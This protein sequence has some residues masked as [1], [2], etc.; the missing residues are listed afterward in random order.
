MKAILTHDGSIKIIL[1]TDEADN[2]I[3]GKFL[4]KEID[5]AGE[6]SPASSSARM[7]MINQTTTI[8]LKRT[9]FQH[10]ADDGDD[11]FSEYK[12]TARHVFM[13]TIC[14]VSFEAVHLESTFDNYYFLGL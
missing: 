12:Q 4:S 1:P 14:H 7:K 2:K 9:L 3:K 10:E 5:S 11:Q 13:S 8:D 6:S